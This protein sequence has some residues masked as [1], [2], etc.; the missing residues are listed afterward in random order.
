MSLV[1]TNQPMG[2]EIMNPKGELRL[3][4]VLGFGFISKLKNNICERKQELNVEMKNYVEN[5]LE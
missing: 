5:S 4:V 1:K 3:I 2:I